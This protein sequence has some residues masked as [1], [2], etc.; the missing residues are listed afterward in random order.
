[1]FQYIQ[2]IAIFLAFAACLA[3]CTNTRVSMREPNSRV[4]FK[5]SDFT[6]SEQLTAEA[7]TNRILGIDWWRLFSKK[8]A[9]VEKDASASINLAT[10]PVIGTAIVDP[11]ASYALYNLISANAGYDVVFYPQYSTTVQRPILG[12]GFLYKKTKVT[13]VARLGKLN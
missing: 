3:S 12:L 13:V 2:K 10:I 8:S 4:N 6:F 1:M 9:A 5:K 11:T 7:T